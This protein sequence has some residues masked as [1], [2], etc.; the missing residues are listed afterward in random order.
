[1]SKLLLEPY[2][3]AEE[4]ERRLGNTRTRMQEQGFDMLL[5]TDPASLLYLTGYRQWSFSRPQVL[6]VP[7]AGDI[8]FFVRAVDL[9][10]AA[11]TTYLSEDRVFGTPESLVDQPD[12][13]P[14]D[15]VAEVLRDRGLANG[16]MA[17]E[18][19]SM[20]YS[21]RTHQALL[22]GL[23]DV[24]AVDAR[25]LVNWVRA[26]K[27]DAEIECMRI[28]GQIAERVVT[29]A[30]DM[31]EPGVRQCDVAAE[32]Y[33]TQV[34]GLEHAGGDFTAAPPLMPSGERTGL[35]HMTWTDEQYNSGE[36][37]VLELGGC[38]Q[39]YNSALARTVFLG[40]PPTRLIELADI[41]GEGLE[42]TLDAIRPG[43][44][45]EE[46]EAVWRKV[47]QRHGL[48]KTSRI[49]YSI[50]LNYPPTWV[51]RT[52]SLRPGDTTVLQP[53]M[54]FHMILGMWQDTWGYEVSETFVVTETGIECLSN[55]PRG[56]TVKK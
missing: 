15:W 25:N 42:T 44:T 28:A 3:S 21:V 46:V 52:M 51:E 10:G 13:H 50:G 26:V 31:I 2:F 33:A 38:Y 30:I 1:M 34:R 6:L 29:K 17:V 35:P 12:S 53:N 54:T 4:Y 14:M 55:Y 40:E 9:T 18:T 7:A 16:I 24:K 11:S 23:P 49:G 19:E 43:V 56:L 45:C 5:V 39:R 47:L 8:L 32:I 48:V 27:S 37:V 41:V 36:P 22:V 20:F